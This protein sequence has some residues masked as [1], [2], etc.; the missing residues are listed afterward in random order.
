MKHTIHL[1]E[2]DLK[3][4]ISESVRRTLNEM[5]TIKQNVLLRKLTGT[6]KY[7]NL[8][9]SDASKMIDDLLKKQPKRLAS[10][11]QIKFLLKRGVNWVKDVEL[12]SEDASFMIGGLM[13]GN[14]SKVDII[15]RKYNLQDTV[16]NN[17]FPI[18]IDNDLEFEL[19]TNKQFGPSNEQEESVLNI[20]DKNITSQKI[21]FHH[22]SFKDVHEY[23]I[24]SN[25]IQIP[26]EKLLTA[27]VITTPDMR[28][29]FAVF[30]NVRF[31]GIEC[32]KVFVCQFVMRM[33]SVM[34]GKS[35]YVVAMLHIFFFKL[36][37]SKIT[38]RKCGMTMEICFI[39]V[40]I[41][42]K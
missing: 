10:E 19:E 14:K 20:I 27:K 38:V 40:F 11:K 42:R 28:I 39:I 4:I 25:N 22:A 32:K 12:T 7:D 36:L 26:S 8:S 15:K 18:L 5:G 29:R 23:F 1:K 21:E 13:N 30:G 35:Y 31:V 16:N 34:I 41:F 24:L 37:R 33:K 2:S 6:D 3:R 9:V 17:N